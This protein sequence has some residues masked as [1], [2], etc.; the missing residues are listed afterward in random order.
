[1]PNARG[2][3]TASSRKPF[4]HIPI[5]WVLLWFAMPTIVRIDGMRVAIYPNDHPPPHV[6]VIGA[7][8]EAVF[9]LNCPDG[10][11]ELRESYGFNG[12]DI[13]RMATALRP[14]IQM[15]CG[16]WSVIHANL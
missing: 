5:G 14:S 8:G 4:R 10:P 12:P 9:L 6:H 16:E 2:A 1:M 15:L 7:K 11:P 13:R 3:W